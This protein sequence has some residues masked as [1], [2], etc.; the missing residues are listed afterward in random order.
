MF[1]SCPLPGVKTEKKIALFH[2]SLCGFPPFS[3]ER[4]ISL[5]VQ[6]KTANFDFPSPWWDSISPLAKDLIKN[7]IVVDPASRLTVQ[8]ALEHPWMQQGSITLSQ[9]LQLSPTPAKADGAPV[10]MILPAISVL[11]PTPPPNVAAASGKGG[12]KGGRGAAAAATAEAAAAAAAAAADVSSSSTASPKASSDE[13][14]RPAPS[15]PTSATA[16]SSS[17]TPPSVAASSSAMD[18]DTP[19]AQKTANKRSNSA[20]AKAS[21]AALSPVS[22]TAPRR[23]ARQQVPQTAASIA[24]ATVAVIKGGDAESPQKRRKQL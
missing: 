20:V 18:V 2:C 8:Q 1:A 5:M 9:A 14:T 12:R 10:R 24:T 17:Q 11:R 15:P 3:D 22:E 7:L 16:S 19:P 6:I 21:A 23:S 13:P 4:N